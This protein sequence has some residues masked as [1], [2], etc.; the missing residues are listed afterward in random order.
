MG[1]FNKCRGYLAFFQTVLLLLVSQIIAL[2]LILYK[3]MID[4]IDP[5]NFP[6]CRIS[7]SF[8]YGIK[9]SRKVHSLQVP[10]AGPQVL[11]G[12]CG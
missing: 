4:K 8:P 2:L 9:K 1:C 7:K 10:V 5:F 3:N 12:A 6:A 11:I